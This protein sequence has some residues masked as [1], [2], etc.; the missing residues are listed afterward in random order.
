MKTVSVLIAAYKAERWLEQCILSV[1]AQTLPAGVALEVLIGIDGCASSLAAAKRLVA[2]NVKVFN[3]PKNN[4][5]FVMFNTLMQ[6]STG[7]WI[8]RFDADDVMH[9]D[10][11]L[12]QMQRL[13]GDANITM[14]WS[15][16]VDEHLRP[17]SI[18]LAN[19][20]FRPARGENRKGAEGCFILERQVWDRL[21]GF[22]PWRWHKR[23]TSRLLK[24]VQRITKMQT[25]YYC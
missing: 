21:G 6:F 17:T 7:D 23:R 19:E 8:C 14:T 5:P 1:Q 9:T 2:G 20:N 25:K 13:S 12:E 24:H 22:R 4:G 18:I 16:F 3:S 11:L 15:I 10:F